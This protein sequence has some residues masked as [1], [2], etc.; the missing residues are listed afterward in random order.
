MDVNF[1]GERITEL[2]IARNV[3]EYQM[4][5]ELGKSKSYI[6]G[7]TS[8]KSLPSMAQLFEI[9]DY[10][11]VSLSEFFDPHNH[12]SP[13]LRDTMAQLRK[14]GRTDLQIIC[15]ITRRMA[16]LTKSEVDESQEK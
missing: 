16:E 1:I 11:G 12:D 7:I 3:S 8:K 4:S 10:L 15:D 14:L 5:L 2:R 6:Q 13:L 9:C